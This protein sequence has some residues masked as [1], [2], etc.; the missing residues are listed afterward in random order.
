MTSRS[1]S[2]LFDLCNCNAPAICGTMEAMAESMS[3]MQNEQPAIPTEAEREI[4]EEIRA[5][6]NEIID[7]MIEAGDFSDMIKFNEKALE[8]KKRHPNFSHVFMYHVLGG[9]TPIEGE[10]FE[11]FDFEGEDSIVTFIREFDQ[12]AKKTATA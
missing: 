5:K 10:T 12:S 7:R 1:M 11:A 2:E 4:A 3:G 8:L 9:S 6:R